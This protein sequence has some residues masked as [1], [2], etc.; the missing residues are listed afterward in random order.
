MTQKGCKLIV[1]ERDITGAH[2]DMCAVHKM[3][4]VAR[5]DD[6][7]CNCADLCPTHRTAVAL[8]TI[9][10]RLAPAGTIPMGNLK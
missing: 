4:G 5:L 8:E 2:V 1:K 10:E 7:T 9:A 3:T 6:G